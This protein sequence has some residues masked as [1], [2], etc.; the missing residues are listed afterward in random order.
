ME[1]VKRRYRFYFNPIQFAAVGFRRRQ[2]L[3]SFQ[4]KITFKFN[5]LPIC[6]NYLVL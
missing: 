5:K 2:H 3:T 4:V 6:A 1:Y